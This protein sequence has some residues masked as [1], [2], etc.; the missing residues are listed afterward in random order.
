MM[1]GVSPYATEARRRLVA[2]AAALVLV[3]AGGAALVRP[4]PAAAAQTV[5]SLTFDDGDATQTTA[6]TLLASHGMHGT[7]FINSPRIGGDSYYMTWPQIAHIAADGNEIAGHTAYHPD[8]TKLDP[9]KA[10]REICYDRN[11]LLDHGYSPQ[12]FAYPFGAYNAS[13]ETLAKDCGYNSARGTGEFGTSC[14]TCS[15]SIPPQDPYATRVVADGSEGLSTIENAVVRA[16]Q[17]GGGW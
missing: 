5:V 6:R 7:F 12:S 10:K 8:P 13:V 14:S 16:E 2:F 3:L 15:E 9:H 17:H 11:L 1:L 4:A